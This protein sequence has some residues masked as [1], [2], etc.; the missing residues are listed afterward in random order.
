MENKGLYYKSNDKWDGGCW[1]TL[2]EE[3]SRVVYVGKR[4]DKTIG[5]HR[6]YW[7]DI[8]EKDEYEKVN[9]SIVRLKEEYYFIDNEIVKYIEILYSLEFAEKSLYLKI[10]YVTDDKT[11]IMLFNC[12]IS[13]ILSKLLQEK[14]SDMF[15]A[16]IGN[17]TVIFSENL[18]FEMLKNNEKDN[19]ILEVKM[20]AQE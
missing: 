20:N 12:G 10:K 17:T 16:D 19:L 4:G 1:N 13:S 14:Y 9:L 6:E 7:T 15:E 18:I 11:K 3:Q 8:T 5:G 2:R